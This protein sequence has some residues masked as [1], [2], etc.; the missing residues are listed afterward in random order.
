M[1]G[2]TFEK[3]GQTKAPRFR[4]PEMEGSAA[5]RYDRLR[6]TSAQQAETRARA[7]QL[8]RGLR[9]GA[10]VLEIAPGPGRFA[11]EMARHGARVTGFDISQTMVEIARGHAEEAQVEVDFH[12]GDATSLPFPDR[13]FDLVVC[14]AAFK[15]FPHP[16]EVLNEMHR[17]LRPGARAVIDDMRR[18]ATLG[19]IRQEV[20]RMQVAALTGVM[21]TAILWGLRRRARTVSA[22]FRLAEESAFDDCTIRTEGI[23]LEVRLTRDLDGPGR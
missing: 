3:P 16:V 18:E 2:T 21:T 1:T 13:S 23:G 17:V 14:Q 8:S 11:I 6:G 9:E 20:R 7:E 5:R 19:D 22:F 10:G 4:L 12:Q 15:N